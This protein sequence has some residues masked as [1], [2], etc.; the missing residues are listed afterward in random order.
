MFIASA[1]AN[2]TRVSFSEINRSTASDDHRKHDTDRC[3]NSSLMDATKSPS[4]NRA[5]SRYNL[6]PFGGSRQKC[7]HLSPV[8]VL[9][10]VLM[11]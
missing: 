1:I 8:F 10:R 4:Y 11:T 6:Q 3:A 9:H 5:L 7:Q 2:E